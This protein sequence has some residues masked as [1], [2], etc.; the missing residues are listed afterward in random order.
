MDRAHISYHSTGIADLTRK[1]QRNWAVV[2]NQLSQDGCFSTFDVTANQVIARTVTELEKRG[3]CKIT[4][5][6]YPW[7]DV[8]LTEKGR[9]FLNDN[10]YTSQEAS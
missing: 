3:Y 4:P 2:L 7:S 5:R 6:T 9:E 1:Q 10:G 8:T